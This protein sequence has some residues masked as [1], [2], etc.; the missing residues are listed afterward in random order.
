MNS[1]T[2]MLAVMSAIAL[3]PLA[4][5]SQQTNKWANSTANTPDTAYDWTVGDHWEN[6]LPPAEGCYVNISPS[7]TL[8]VRLSEFVS[9]QYF[10]GNANVRYL[11]NVSMKD[12]NV[13]AK[14]DRATFYSS[15]YHY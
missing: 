3:S 10:V 13:G 1:K 7:K 6:G 8:Y 9:P 4:V 11:G 2:M 12:G 14:R 5:L 15:G